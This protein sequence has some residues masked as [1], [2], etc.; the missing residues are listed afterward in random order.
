MLQ[1]IFKVLERPGMR[2]Q[3]IPDS[4][5]DK[6]KS[7]YSGSSKGI[8]KPSKNFYEKLYTNESTSKTATTEFP[9]KIFRRKKISNEQ[10][11]RCE[12]FNY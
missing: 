6:N 11:N 7:K 9:S 5:T 4:Y 8:L 1:K 3:I 2:N 12:Q 10:F